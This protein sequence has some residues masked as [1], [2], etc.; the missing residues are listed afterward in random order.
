MSYR[1]SEAYD[2]SLF[3]PQVVQPDIKKTE[4]APKKADAPKRD[5]SRSNNTKKKQSAAV[6]R[7]SEGLAKATI[8]EER[9]VKEC[10]VNAAIIKAVA[11]VAV[12][13]S[14]LVVYLAL[15]GANYSVKKQI[16]AKNNQISVA[17][18][19][20]VR[21]SS[22]L[23]SLIATDRIEYLAENALG[24]CKADSQQIDYFTRNNGDRIVVSGEKVTDNGSQIVNKIKELIAYIL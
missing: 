5:A 19:E 3:E 14:L 9:N 17:Q 23:S 10:V 24:M 20:Y 16:S 18:S 8:N 22:E 1:S 2:F 13:T 21:L 4:R 15:A 12:C 7:A 11:F 6:R